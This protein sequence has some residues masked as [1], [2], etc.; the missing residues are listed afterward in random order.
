MYKAPIFS[1]KNDESSRP[2][3]DNKP[4]INVVSRK[5]ILS[6][7]QPATGDRRNVVPIVR[8]PTSAAN[9]KTML[10]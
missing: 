2:P 3:E 4:P 1:V 5:P 6:V 7:K 8:E 9:T 10:I